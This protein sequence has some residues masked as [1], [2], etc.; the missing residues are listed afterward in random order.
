[1]HPD[2]IVG[3]CDLPFICI[4]VSIGPFGWVMRAWKRFDPLE[5]GS[6]VPGNKRSI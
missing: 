3:S 1:M 4:T 5:L 2:S 6:I